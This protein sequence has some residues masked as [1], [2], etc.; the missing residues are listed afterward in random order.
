MGRSK[1][2]KLVGGLVNVTV[3]LRSAHSNQQDWERPVSRIAK[4]V[5]CYCGCYC[6]FGYFD[7][8]GYYFNYCYDC[9]FGYKLL[10][11]FLVILVTIVFLAIMVILVK[12]VV[13]VVVVILAPGTL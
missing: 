8:C 6:S 13:A 7:Y 12:M 5:F 3:V 1:V 2:D 11:I 4:R 10:L 9:C